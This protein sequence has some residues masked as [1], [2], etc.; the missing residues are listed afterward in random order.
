MRDELRSQS[1]L[2]ILVRGAAPLRGNCTVVPL[3]AASVPSCPA[4][5]PPVA[6]AQDGLLPA[7]K[8]T[9]IGSLRL[10]ELL[11]CLSDGN[12]VYVFFLGFISNVVVILIEVK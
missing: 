9:T 8:E 6:P 7:C 1:P 11:I 3:E 10:G 2:P 12:T 4:T 5:G